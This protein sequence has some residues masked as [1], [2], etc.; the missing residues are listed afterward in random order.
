MHLADRVDRIQSSKTVS[1]TNTV[2]KMKQEG[3]DVISLGAG[4][5]DFETPD[6]I[7]KAAIEAIQTGKTKYTQVMGIPE[8]RKAIVEKFKRDND[9]DYGIDRVVVTTGGKQ[10]L[11][12][13]VLAICQEG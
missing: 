1:I 13:A 9:L 5:P 12:N 11:F 7:K 8:L 4:E 6:F 2:L 10:A 3:Y